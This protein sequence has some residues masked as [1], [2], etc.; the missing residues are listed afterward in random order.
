V[1]TESVLAEIEAERHLQIARG[2]DAAHDDAHADGEII[3]DGWGA[4]MRL[5]LA[6]ELKTAGWNDDVYRKIL[7]QSAALI[8]AEMERLERAAGKGGAA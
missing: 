8:V 6:C 2:Y 4:R 3:W 7:R 1:S 5:S